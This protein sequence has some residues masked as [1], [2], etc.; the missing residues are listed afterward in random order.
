MP[1]IM[2]RVAFDYKV[3]DCRTNN[4]IIFGNLEEIY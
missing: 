1:L 4:Q 3:C 2:I